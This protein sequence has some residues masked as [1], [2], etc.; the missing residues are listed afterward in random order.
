M[1]K[2]EVLLNSYAFMIIISVHME[3]FSCPRRYGSEADETL[4][5]CLSLEKVKER[6]NDI[7]SM[8]EERDSVKYIK[9]NTRKQP[10][11]YALIRLANGNMEEYDEDR[12]EELDLGKNERAATAYAKAT[13]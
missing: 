10:P 7:F 9:D 8:T 6:N 1:G 3:I 4:V 11:E 5:F 12:Q 13:A 2:D